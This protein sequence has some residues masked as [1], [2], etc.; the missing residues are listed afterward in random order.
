MTT[1]V[2]AERI[3]AP[4]LAVA[5]GRDAIHPP[6]T[7][8]ETAKRVGAQLEVASEMSHWLPGE[9]GWDRIAALCLDWS[10]A[11]DVSLAAAE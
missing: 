2:H 8:R 11:V 4:I 1:M 3:R 7:V 9:P 5:G 6:A 10:A